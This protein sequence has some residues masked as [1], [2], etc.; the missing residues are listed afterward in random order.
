MQRYIGGASIREIAREEHRGRATITKIVRSAE[1]NSFVQKMRERFYGLGS[2]ALG[3]VQHALQTEKDARLGYQL[4]TDIGVVPSPQE[5]YEIATQPVRST[6]TPFEIAVAEDENGRIN[7]IAY[8]MACVIEES[9]NFGS[10]L[11]TAE[12]YRHPKFMLARTRGRAP[13]T[14]SRRSIV[15][16]LTR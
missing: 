3:A 7:Q 14:L 8:G 12:E 2:D 6:M 5:R 4:L 15:C 9:A 10:H 11:P 1:M 16:R 13:T